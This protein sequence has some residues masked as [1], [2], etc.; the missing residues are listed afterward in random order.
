MFNHIRDYF[1]LEFYLSIS[2]T[3]CLSLEAGKEI[4]DEEATHDNTQTEIF[5]DEAAHDNT[6]TE[7]RQSVASV[8]YCTVCLRMT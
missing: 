4:F 2:Q 6:E 8:P 1:A 7:V 3:S 5:D